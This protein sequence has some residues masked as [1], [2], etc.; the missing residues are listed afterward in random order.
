MARKARNTAAAAIDRSMAE[1]TPLNIKPVRNPEGVSGFQSDMT[2]RIPQYNRK[3]ASP[4]DRFWHTLGK[5]VAAGRDTRGL[6]HPSPT[7]FRM[8]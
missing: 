3:T 6:R 1:A 7:R 8:Y 5:L 4:E 2:K